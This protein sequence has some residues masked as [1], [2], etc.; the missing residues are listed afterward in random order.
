MMRIAMVGPFGLHPNKT[1]QSRAL[2]LARPL[3]RS[4]HEICIFMPPWQ[5]PDEAD[6]RWQE[7]GVQMRYIPL[8]GGTPGIAWRLLRETLAWQPD[9]VHCF[10]PKAYSGMVGWWLWQFQRHKLP[11]VMDTDDWEGW[12]GWNELA[13]YST[14]QKHFFA[15]QEQWGMGHCHLLT[16]A[17]RELQAIALHQGIPDAQ[18]AYIPN[19]PGIAHDQ[20]PSEADILAKRVE[21]GL[22]QRPTL[23]LYSRLFEFD[24]QRL[25]DVLVGV[26]TAVPDLAI[27]TIGTGLYEDNAAALRTLLTE[28]NL[29]TAVVDVG[30]VELDRLP[31]LLSCADVGL[32]L[33]D[34]TLLNRTKCPVKLADMAAMG[35]PVVGEAVG[36]VTEYVVNGRTGSLRPSGAT[37]DLAQDIIILL[38]NPELRHQFSQA[39][40]NHIQTHFSWQNLAQQLEKEYAIIAA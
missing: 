23:L 33:M 12:G 14:V 7:D 18:I 39:A 3:T 24:V 1:M 35:V 22:E 37:A 20:P 26:Q 40:R 29:L 21:L 36:Q 32:Y 2:G 9:I 13:P 15:W 30:W 6:R 4:G 10:K 5:T 16:T 27:L 28:A 34:D 11:L 19:G 8:S 31:L 17:S 25:V 38:Q